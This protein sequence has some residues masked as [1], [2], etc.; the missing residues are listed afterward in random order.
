MR[1]ACDAHNFLTNVEGCSFLIVDQL[2]ESNA[3]VVV[4]AVAS[5]ASAFVACAIAVA[6]VAA[7]GS[8]GPAAALCVTA[9][10][11]ID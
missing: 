3:A 5:Y 2:L 6:V 8:N 9:A 1:I 11:L 10:D 7:A 4:A